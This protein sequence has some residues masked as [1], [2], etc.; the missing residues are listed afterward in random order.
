MRKVINCD[1]ALLNF[2]SSQK[3]LFGKFVDGSEKKDR[4][5]ALIEK[6]EDYTTFVLTQNL[7]HHRCQ[8]RKKQY[9][10]SLAGHTDGK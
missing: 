3:K 6:I 8:E 5:E 1:N 2:D 9:K 10:Q 7:K 4:L